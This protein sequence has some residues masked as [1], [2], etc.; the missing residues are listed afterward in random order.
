MCLVEV[1]LF[2]PFSMALSFLI[3]LELKTVEIS[4]HFFT[5]TSLL[6]LYENNVHTQGEYHCCGPQNSAFL[7]KYPGTYFLNQLAQYFRHRNQNLD[8]KVLANHA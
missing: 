6:F 4:K 1:S 3:F 5:C 7:A 2:L 8:L